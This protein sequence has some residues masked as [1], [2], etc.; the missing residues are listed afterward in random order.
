MLIRPGLLWHRAHIFL[1]KYP[2]VCNIKNLVI[3]CILFPYF[4]NILFCK[5]VQVCKIKSWSYKSAIGFSINE[6]SYSTLFHIVC[7]L[8]CRLVC[9]LSLGHNNY[10]WVYFLSISQARLAMHSNN[11]IHF[12]YNWFQKYNSYDLNIHFWNGF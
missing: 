3:I 2:T 7:P 4:R 9:L 1:Y 12:Y 6:F 5:H 10:Y 8:F 11:L